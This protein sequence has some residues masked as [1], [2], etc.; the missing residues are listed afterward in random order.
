MLIRGFVKWGCNTQ[1]K[2]QSPGSCRL[3]VASAGTGPPI[4]AAT[5]RLPIFVSVSTS[6]GFGCRSCLPEREQTASRNGDTPPLS[7]VVTGRTRWC[8]ELWWDVGARWARA[9]V[10]FSLCLL[11]TWVTPGK[12]GAYRQDGHSALCPA[13]P[14]SPTCS[15]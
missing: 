15:R 12:R 14:A 2:G 8:R 7:P 10:H 9:V 13:D 1:L 6:P 11:T 4:A 3:A 5:R